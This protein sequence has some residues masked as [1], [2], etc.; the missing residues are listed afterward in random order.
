MNRCRLLDGSWSS[1]ELHN[2]C[3]DSELQ[4]RGGIKYNSKIIFLISQQKNICCDPSLELSRQDGSN[5]VSQHVSK[6]Y[7][8]KLSLN[9]PFLPLLIWCTVTDI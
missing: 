5:D 1:L 2:F 8:G 7:Y 3:T 6:E 9:Y 4:I